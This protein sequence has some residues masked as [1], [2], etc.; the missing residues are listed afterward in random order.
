VKSCLSNSKSWMS[1][2]LNSLSPLVHHLTS[3][4]PE[5]ISEASIVTYADD[6]TVYLAHIYVDTDYNGLEKAADKILLY[7]RSNCLAANA[8]KTKFVM[9]GRKKLSKIRVGP[10]YGEESEAEVLLGVKMSKN[11]T[12]TKQVEELRLELSRRVG[13]IRRLSPQMPRHTI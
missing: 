4:M 13:I 12:W 1:A 5:A 11:L 7:M 3:N 8:E 10:G 9:F 2:R 6:T